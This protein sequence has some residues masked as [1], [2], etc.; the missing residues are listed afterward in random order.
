[1]GSSWKESVIAIVSKRY[2]AVVEELIAT[3]TRKEVAL[4]NRKTRRIISGGISDGEKVKQQLFL[5]YMEFSNMAESIG[6][7]SIV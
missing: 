4:K 5:D 6:V 2:R 3:V 7:V 1:M